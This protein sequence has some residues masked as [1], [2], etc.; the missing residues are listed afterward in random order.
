MTETAAPSIAASGGEEI[1]WELLAE[2]AQGDLAWA[3]EEL[4]KLAAAIKEAQRRA[5]AAALAE[6]ER[7]R[8]LAV[9]A[10]A[11][12]LEFCED[13]PY[14][15]HGDHTRPFAGLLDDPEPSVDRKGVPGA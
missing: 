15:A 8:A 4:D 6:R 9:S 3:R 5:E 7:I 13:R 2:Q 11:V 14:C 1:A 10:N 12:Y